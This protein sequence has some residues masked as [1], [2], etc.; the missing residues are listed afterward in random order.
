[1]KG[2]E[3]NRGEWAACVVCEFLGYV[4]FCVKGGLPKDWGVNPVL[5]S[6]GEVAFC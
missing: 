1:L 2:V 4:H 5:Y 3:P 6:Q